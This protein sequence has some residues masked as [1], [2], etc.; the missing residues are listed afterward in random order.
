MV[1]GP[2]GSG[3]T[4]LLEVLAGIRQ[5][6]GGGIFY[7]GRRLAPGS[8]AQYR[9]IRGFCPAVLWNAPA[10]TAGAALQWAAALW[11]VAR[12]SAAIARE[13]ARWRLEDVFRQRIGNLS[14]GYQ[15][16]V[17]LAASLVMRPT[18][19]IVDRPYEALD[20]EGRVVVQTVLA[21][22]LSGRHGPE[23]P[24]L[25]LLADAAPQDLPAPLAVTTRLRGSSITIGRLGN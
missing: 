13:V 23:W 11:E 5:P 25:A 8:L 4:T 16:R 14:A 10:M 3:K 15:R 7:E 2:S 20:L 22:V 9:A 1:N 24:R 18:I 17:L 21:G 6:S 12:P 19:W